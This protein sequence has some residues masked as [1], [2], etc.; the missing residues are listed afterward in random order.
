MHLTAGN[1]GGICRQIVNADTVVPVNG[2]IPNRQ[3]L[4]LMS[5][6]ANDWQVCHGRAMIGLLRRESICLT[7]DQAMSTDPQPR[8]PSLTGEPPWEAAA[9]LPPQGR[10]TEADFLKFH[11]NRMAELVD[12]RLE[13]LPM[14]SMLHQLIVIFFLDRIREHLSRRSQQGLTLMAP[15]PVHLFPGTI[16]EPDILYVSPE[17]LPTPDEPYPSK[18]DVAIEVV[19]EGKDAYQR[20]YEQKRI[21][22]ARA[23]V[24][25]YWIVDPQKNLI[26]VLG[27]EGDQYTLLGEYQKGD[28]ASGNYFGD[29]FV[30]VTEVF[31]VAD[32]K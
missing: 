13:V 8:I 4:S 10:W 23:G 25:E 20:D 7:R 2:F 19:S 30:A 29:F 24:S 32:K 15:L 3:S 31:A 28:T 26:T 6:V 22:Y 27:L 1:W 16:R 11:T 17:N 18:I 12:G 21:D 9:L 5:I 14:P